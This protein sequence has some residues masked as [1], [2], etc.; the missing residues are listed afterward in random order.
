MVTERLL[1]HRADADLLE[2]EKIEDNLAG[3]TDL[4]PLSLAADK[5]SS[6]LVEPRIEEIVNDIVTICR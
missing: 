5:G 4:A 1:K 3:F 6:F 2:N